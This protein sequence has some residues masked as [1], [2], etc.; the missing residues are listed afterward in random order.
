MKVS[1]SSVHTFIG[2]ENEIDAVWES[3]EYLALKE[4]DSKPVK[5]L[6][7]N[8]A[9]CLSGQT[10]RHTH[11]TIAGFGCDRKTLEQSPSALYSHSSNRIWRH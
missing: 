7:T 4:Q 11:T 8:N 6:Q 1:P 9:H 2:I 5:L 10:D 3:D